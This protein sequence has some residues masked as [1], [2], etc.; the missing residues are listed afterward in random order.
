MMSDTT[1]DVMTGYGLTWNIQPT[2]AYN[3]EDQYYGG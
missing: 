2:T 1:A 3:N